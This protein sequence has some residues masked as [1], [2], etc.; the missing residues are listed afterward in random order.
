MSPAQGWAWFAETGVPAPADAP[1]FVTRCFSTPDGRRTLD[2]LKAMTLERAAGPEITDAALRHLEGQ[3]C[4]VALL[5][6][7]VARGRDE[8]VSTPH[9]QEFP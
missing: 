4:L 5:L 2:L 7:L 9:P 3:R 6:A 1:L 8:P